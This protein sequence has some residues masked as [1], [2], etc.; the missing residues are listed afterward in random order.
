MRKLV[1]IAFICSIL[2]GK[3]FA[4]GYSFE[5]VPN[6]DLKARIYTLD[7]GLKVY[8]SV[9]K[10]EPKVRVTIATNAGS[11]LDPA[12]TTGLAH[13]F[14][15]LMFKGSEH[16]GTSNYAVEKPL[17]DEI[18]VLFE[19]YRKETDNKK[20]RDIYRKIDSV[21]QL[22]SKYAIPNEYDKLMSIVGSTFT[23]AGTWVDFTNYYEEIPSNQLDN[24]FLIQ[25]D[26]FQYPVLRLFHTELE[27]IYEEKNMTLTNDGR[28]VMASMMEGMFPNHPY[29]TQTTIGTQEHLRTPSITNVKK[30]F[31]TYYVPN[32]MAIIMAGDFDPDETIKIIDKY[33]GKMEYKE[34]PKFTYTPETPI[35]SSVVKEV[36]GKSA[37]NLSIA[38]RV[39]DP[40]SEDYPLMILTE[41]ILTNGHAGLVD[42][43]INQ[44]QRALNAGS[45]PMVLHDYC[46]V[47][48]VA[49]PKAG[50]TLDEV[51]EILLEQID[52]LQQG[53]FP[54]WLLSACVND[55]RVREIQECEKND[56][57]V[58][59]MEEAFSLGI[60][61]KD[62]VNEV[63][64]MRKYTKQDVVNYAKK[65]FGRNNYVIV[66]KRKGEPTDIEKI[67][68]PK[69]TSISIDRDSKSDFVKMIEE[70]EAPKIQPVF[71]DFN[72]DIHSMDVKNGVKLYFNKNE[73][74]DLFNLSYYFKIGKG[75]DKYLEL[76]STYL[77]YLG[78][79][80]YTAEQLKEEFYKIGCT[81]TLSASS[82]QSGVTISGLSENMEKAID[83]FEH[84]IAHA[85]PNQEALDNVVDDVLKLRDNAKHNPNSMAAYLM[86]YGTYGTESEYFVNFI[87]EK[88][89]KSLT[90]EFLIGKLKEWINYKHLCVYYGPQDA[91]AVAA[92]IVKYHNLDNLKETLPEVIFTPQRPASDR[93]FVA[94]FDFPQNILYTV[95]IGGKYDKKLSPVVSLYNDYFGGSMNSIVFQELRESRS[96]AYSAAAFYIS[97]DRPADPYRNLTFIS[98]GPDKLNEA[99]TAFNDLLANMPLNDN[100][101][102]IAKDAAINT[103]ATQRISPKL[104]VWTYL[105]W[106]DFGFTDDPRREQF[107]AL[108]DLTM[109][110]MSKFQ[111]QYIAPLPKTYIIV[112][113]TANM[114]MKFLKS[115]GKTKVLKEKV[116]FGY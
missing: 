68:N 101:F 3:L 64:R 51:K 28:R 4:Q 30:F 90:P 63:E 40:R 84:V 92:S 113:N 85:Q 52:K 53:D 97:P 67:K 42:L 79:D 65:Y 59:I 91:K 25:A 71:I 74:N 16:F 75:Q 115:L 81:Y 43:N 98:A 5:S 77:D 32:N 9:N 72:K 18:E 41:M 58:S 48:M 46:Y 57:R 110:D 39:A 108:K 62:K 104:L 45:Y 36:V 49:S 60:S 78:T 14:E 24:F 107:G 100:S 33:F 21:S 27:T 109:N 86:Q 106:V 55:L 38:W 8:M 11:K 44:K 93:V 70:R 83:L 19:E 7:N 69:I 47:Q 89:L 102:K 22:A 96:L 31:D 15:H 34:L 80:K 13:Y 66:Y 73:D 23:N 95:G 111:K 76:A 1:I 105:D 94:H 12:E 82:T 114:D 2:T 116:F 35:T 50:Q 26:R 112:G 87:S 37:E 61:W 29:G 17:L 56:G 99:I 10:A 20:R 103:M 88:E 54:E 6:D